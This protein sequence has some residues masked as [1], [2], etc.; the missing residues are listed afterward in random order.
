MRCF[1][2]APAVFLLS[3]SLLAQTSPPPDTKASQDSKSLCVVAGRVVTAAEGSPLKS[4]RV[5][6]MPERS[7][8]HKEVYAATSDADGHFV[9]KDVPSGRYQFFANRTGFVVQRYK[10]KDNDTGAVFSLREA[11]KVSDVLFRMTVAAV[12]TGRVAKRG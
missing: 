3:V 8:M 2:P 5:V 6:L 1:L 4:A 10:A 11:E 12:I 7:E 9:I